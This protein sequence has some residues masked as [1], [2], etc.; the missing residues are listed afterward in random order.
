MV[1]HQHEVLGVK[2]IV[3]DTSALSSDNEWKHIL[4]ALHDDGYLLYCSSSKNYNHVLQLL[5]QHQITEYFSMVLSRDQIKKPKPSPETYYKCCLAAGLSTK[6]V[7]IID[8]SQ[9]GKQSARAS[10]CHLFKPETVTLD[11]IKE[12]IQL[13]NEFEGN[14]PVITVWQ[15]HVQVI[16]PLAEHDDAFIKAGFAPLVEVNGKLMLQNMVQNLNMSADFIFVV[17]HEM[18]EKY[19]LK[20]FL[21]SLDENSKSK[22]V[23]F[24]G[25]TPTVGAQVLACADVLDPNEPVIVTSCSQYLEWDSNAFLYALANPSVDGGVLTFQN[26]H[27]RYAFVSLDERGW[28]VDADLHKPISLNACAGIFHF[29]KAKHLIKYTST[30]VARGLDTVDRFGIV[31]AFREAVKDGKKIRNYQCRRMWELSSPKDVDYFHM[32]SKVQ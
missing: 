1:N 20:Y 26:Q 24:E 12:Q 7:M 13:I 14:N 11:A 3:F 19:K 9:D 16:V 10:G 29:K 18:C 17:S 6:E 21:E 30:A 27:P 2:M 15:Q 8:A 28:I 22:I 32:V 31:Y 25:K 4:G 5:N 23:F